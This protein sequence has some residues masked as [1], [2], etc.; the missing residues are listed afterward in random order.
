MP[1][2]VTER[3]LLSRRVFCAGAS[4][5]GA[6]GSLSLATTVQVVRIGHTGTEAKW[7]VI[8]E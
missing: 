8:S 1:R 3:R 5:G 7:G 4:D 6:A 2:S